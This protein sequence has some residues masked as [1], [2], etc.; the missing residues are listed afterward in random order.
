MASV[1]STNIIFR[2]LQ[3]SLNYVKVRYHV[4][5]LAL[6]GSHARGDARE[7]SDIGILVLISKGWSETLHRGCIWQ[8]GRCC[9]KKVNS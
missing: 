3:D 7:D 1:L 5:K 4:D 2:S 9:S 8:A 6:F